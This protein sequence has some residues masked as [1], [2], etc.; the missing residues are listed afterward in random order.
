MCQDIKLISL[1][2]TFLKLIRIY[3]TSNEKGR[4]IMNNENLQQK[5]SSYI[6][7]FNDLKK[8]MK[9]KVTDTRI[10]MAIASLYVMNNKQLQTDQLLKIADQI[11]KQATMFSPMKS[12]P[13][14]MTAA[15]L[16]VHFDQP[17][18]QVEKIFEYYENFRRAKFKSS[19][20]TYISSS[21][22]VTNQQQ[23]IDPNQVILRTKD[24]YGGMKKEHPFLTSDS[25]YPL[26]TLLAYENK[27]RD[28]L[29]QKIEHFYDELHKNGFKKGN[30]L[31]FISHILSLNNDEHL[32]V[33]VN[34][35]IRLFDRIQE[36]GIKAKPAYYPI[37]GMLAF[38]PE[39]DTDIKEIK[40]IYQQLNHEKHFK[41]QKDTNLIMAVSFF[42][43]DK[44]AHDQLA[45]TSI[46][47]TIEMIIQAQQA[48]MIAI[49]V[50]AS[51]SASNRNS[52]QS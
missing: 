18:D 42:V 39:E 9:W 3:I 47:T 8:S 36:I 24:I 29:I 7:L 28:A 49:A 46:H 16:D 45:E 34:R 41:W 2:E 14:F 22:L 23:E 19:V 10:L 50:S 6:H 37:I 27:S 4:D 33:L 21:I 20:F 13:R 1:N 15:L 44:L 31:Q 51:I 48:L 35:S 43:K 52:N 38:L 40:K 12:Q 11:K 5:T 30:N 25:D 26:A 32:D 17:E